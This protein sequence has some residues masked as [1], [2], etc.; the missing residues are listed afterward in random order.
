MTS[1]SFS[2]SSKP[3]KLSSPAPSSVVIGVPAAPVPSI[4]P[5]LESTVAVGSSI[6]GSPESGRVVGSLFTVAVAF[7]ITD[8]PGS[9]GVVGSLST[10]AFSIT[11]SPE[12]GGVVGSLSTV[13]VASSIVG[14]GSTGSDDVVGSLSTVA[15]GCSTVAP[16]LSEVGA[17]SLTASLSGVV[18][19]HALRVNKIVRLKQSKSQIFDF[20]NIGISF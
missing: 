2:I 8:S 9:G 5:L 20:L 12:S 13:A 16:P 17:G 6:A 14:V 15:V 7:S 18:S 19:P 1:A 3:G 4:S 11:D 10:V